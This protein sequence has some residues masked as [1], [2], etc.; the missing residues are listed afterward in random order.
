MVGTVS[1]LLVI[2]R[3]AMDAPTKKFSPLCALS[4]TKWSNAHVRPRNPATSCMLHQPG[5]VS[6]CCF[7]ATAAACEGHCG[8]TTM[9]LSGSL[10]A[11]VST[12]RAA[13][14]RDS[15]DWHDREDQEGSSGNGAVTSP[16]SQ[17]PQGPGS[18]YP[19]A[20]AAFSG[21]AAATAADLAARVNAA[22]AAAG[23]AT[24]FPD[25]TAGAPSAA[26]RPSSTC[27]P[28]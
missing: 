4:L 14:G 10:D 8:G 23:K 17:A 28:T 13:G 6:T 20:T 25:P 1:V 3:T 5:A 27:N 15:D 22:N 11:D 7:F 21:T 2:L 19:R 9:Y 24:A 26:G 18:G 12:P 16:Q